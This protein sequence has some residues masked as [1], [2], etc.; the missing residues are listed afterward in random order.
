MKF[1]EAERKQRYIS[2][3]NFCPECGSEEINAGHSTFENTEAWQAVTCDDCD[4]EWHDLFTLTGYELV[5]EPA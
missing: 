5:V 2:D 4:A 1:A 3:P